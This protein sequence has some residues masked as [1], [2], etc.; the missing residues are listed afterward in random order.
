MIYLKSIS[1]PS[2]SVEESIIN[3]MNIFNSYYPL[4]M[5]SRKKFEYIEFEPI[6][7]FYGGN[8]SGKTTLLNIISAALNARRRNNDKMGELFNE[9]VEYCSDSIELLNGGECKE[10]KYISSDDIF[11]YLLDIRAINSDV[12]RKKDALVNEYYEYKFNSS[13]DYDFSIEEYDKIKNVV[14]SK[15]STASTYVRQRLKKNNIIQESNGETA[16]GFWQNEIDSNAI[17]I[18]DEPENSLSAENELKLK[19]FIEESANFFNCQ[20]II[21]TH[22]PFFLALD[23]AKVYD[24]DSSP[25]IQ[26][27]WTE[28]DNVIIYRNFFKEHEN[29]FEK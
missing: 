5:F 11:D 7:C 16:L 13:S 20:F 8:G 3:K 19:K 9:Y 18:I 12:N 1:L 28:L 26:K 10:I 15:R 22:S 2:A 6:T 29:E 17:Y 4:K 24:L 21:A 25:V 23:G 27:K 14:E